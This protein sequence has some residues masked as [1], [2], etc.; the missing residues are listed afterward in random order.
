MKP[1]KQF[2]RRNGKSRNVRLH[3]NRFTAYDL[4]KK[5]KKV[6]LQPERCGDDALRRLLSDENLIIACLRDGLSKPSVRLPAENGTARLLN[7]A[8]GI[9]SG[10]E[11]KCELENILRDVHEFDSA[12][13]LMIRELALLPAALR[14]A[15]CEGLDA[16]CGDILESAKTRER[17]EK[18]VRSGGTARIPKNSRDVFFAHALN[19]TEDR[20]IPQLR[21]KLNSMLSERK[22]RSEWALENAHRI[23]AHNMLRLENL[24]HLK[25]LLDSAD[26]QDVFDALSQA[27]AE[28]AE[29][30]SGVY[31]NMDADSRAWVRSSL[32]YLSRKLRISE[33]VLARHALRLAQS[34]Q[35]AD[36]NAHQS[37]VCWYL[38]DDDGRALLLK[39][40]NIQKRIQKC[41]PDRTGMISVSVVCGLTLLL[42]AAMYFVM[43]RHVLMLYAL[44]LAWAAAIQL[45]SRFFPKFVR[46]GKLLRIELKEIPDH[47]RT[48]VTLPVLISSADRAHEMLRRMEALGCLERDKNID[49]LLLG[50]F[51]DADAQHTD[52]DD[53]ILSV[54]REGIARMN[55]A[56]G[57]EKYFYLHR[58]RSW[59]AKDSRWMGENRKRGAITALNRLL[60][61]KSDDAAQFFSAEHAAAEKL[62]GRYRF[63]LTLDADT[64]YLPGTVHKLVG[65]MLHPMNC[66]YA[67]LQPN[68]QLTVDAVRNRYTALTAG[69][70]GVD[71]YSCRVS[72]FYQD[73]TGFG[74]FAG[75]GIYDI[76]RFH[77]STAGRLPDDAILSHDLIEGILSGT[78][79]VNDISFYDGCPENLT[80][81][82]VRLHRWTRGDWQLLPLIFARR[83]NISL[84]DRM[85][86]AGNLIASLSMPALAGL[87]LHSVWLDAPTAFAVGLVF[88]FLDPLLHLFTGGRRLWKHAALRLAVL[89]VYAR[90][91]FDA[92]ARTIWR[93]MFTGKHLMDWIPAADAGSGSRKMHVPGRTAALLLLPGLLRPQWVPAVLA[94]GMLFWVGTDWADDLA[95]E[96]TD[97]CGR[98][99]SAQIDLLN[100][101]AQETWRFFLQ[102]VPEDGC[103]LPPDNVQK[104]P[105]QGIAMRT[106]PTNIG[107]YMMSCLAAYELGYEGWDT[108]RKRLART[109]D[110]LEKLE[111]WNGQ[112]YNW[113]DIAGLVP[114]RPRY[115]SAVD[116][117][118]LAAVLLL[119]A[120]AVKDRDS[121]LGRRLRML[122][123]NMRLSMLYDDERR[124]FRIGAD[125]ENGRLSQSYYDLYASESRILS[126]CAMML[127]EAPVRHWKQLSR[128]LVRAGKGVALA[129]WSG[130]MFEYMMPEL[131]LHSHRMSLTGQ[132]RIAA[133]ECQKQQGKRCRRPW[134]V[135]E[136]GY[137]AF[138][139]MLNYQYRAFGL[140]ML[141]LN[142]D[143]AENV[144]A[145]YASALALCTCAGD[146]ADNLRK[147]RSMGWADEYGMLE[148]ADYLKRDPKGNP[149]LVQSHMAHHQGMILCALCNALRDNTLCNLF[150]DIPEARALR[151]LLQEKPARKPRI[152]GELRTTVHNR[153]EFME[154]GYGRRAKKDTLAAEVHLLHGAGTTALC[155]ANGAVY[156]WNRGIQLNRFSGDLLNEHEGMCVHLTDAN[157]GES[158]VFGESGDTVF[159]AGC[160]YTRETIGGAEAELQTAVSPETGALIQQITL[161]NR[162]DQNLRIDVA[163]C[164]S[165][166]LA[167][168]AD[169]RAHPAFQNLFVKTEKLPGNALCFIRKPRS[170]DGK[171]LRMLYC[172]S[173][174]F[175]ADVETDFEK[176]IGRTGALG[177]ANG[178]SR[179]F[180]GTT[181]SVLNPCGAIR[182]HVQL[183]AGDTR[184]LCFRLAAG[185]EMP[186]FSAE[187]TLR[188]AETH[189]AAVLND[190][191]IDARMHRLVQRASAFLLDAGLKNKRCTQRNFSRK[192]LWRAGISGDMPILLAEID[193]PEQLRN[194]RE[195]IRIHGFY[196]L[197]GVYSDLVILD[198]CA[199]DYHQPEQN[200]LRDM[201]SAGHLS[202]LVSVPGGVFLLKNPEAGTA[203]AL[204]CAAALHFSGSESI[205]VQLRTQLTALYLRENRRFT[206]VRCDREL[207][208]GELEFGCAYGG[209]DR[210][211]YT[212]LPG[213]G[214][215]PPAPWSNIICGGGFGALLTD[216][217]GGFAWLDNSRNCR[218]T[219]FSNDALQEG[220]GWM[221]YLLDEKKGEYL[222]LLPGSEPLTR[223]RVHFAPNCCE[224]ASQTDS[225]AFSAEFKPVDGGMCMR[226]RLR[227]KSEKQLN[228]RL[229]CVVDW[230]MGTDAGDAALLRTWH[231]QGACFARG[232][233][234]ITSFLASDDPNA[235]A[236]CSRNDFLAGGNLMEPR[237]FD[238]LDRREGG[239]VLHMP[240]NIPSGGAA[241]Y[242][243]LLGGAENTKAAQLKIR[244]FRSGRLR[245]VTGI[246]GL[247]RLIVETPDPAVNRMANGFL[248]AQIL[249]GRI[250]GRTGLYQPGG[251]YGFRDQLQDMLAMIHYRPD[252]VRAHLLKC[253]SRQ[254]E[255]G[256]VLHWWHEPCTGVRT[257][258]SDDLLFLPYVTARYV[259]V[260]GDRS[261]LS[262]CIPYLK[263][264]DIPE[265][266]EDV[267]AEMA[268]SEISESLHSHCMR[269]FRHADRSGMHGLCLMGSGD[270]NDGMNRIGAKGSGESIWLSEFMA[271]CAAEYAGIVPDESD[272]AYLTALNER[273]ITA[274]ETT[275]WDGEWYLRAYGDSGGKIGSVENAECRIDVISQAWAELCGLDGERCASALDAAWRYLADEDTGVIR[276]LT[277][278]FSQKQDVGYIAAYPEGIRE[279]GAQYTHGACWLLCALIHA[280]DAERAHKALHML[281]PVYHADTKEKADIYR[282]EP[283]VMAADVYTD[284]LHS[285]RG[286]WTWYTGA[287][288]WMLQAIWMLLGYERRENRVRLN[289][290]L[291]SWRQA[292]VTVRYGGSEYRLICDANCRITL[293]DGI[294][295]DDAFIEMQD[296]G[297]KHTAVFPPR[298]TGKKAPIPL[299]SEQAQA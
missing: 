48:I 292:S 150:M 114:L 175:T 136:S 196:R 12:N 51:R 180:T 58:E 89:P 207:P 217:A 94:L 284:A 119:C 26:W 93:I 199:G 130:T 171:E 143:A 245:T 275:G 187:R 159:E 190:S 232:A 234:E 105:P 211:G 274:I 45:I 68:M 295:L 268:D 288:S 32:E 6:N 202:E 186:P 225:L 161:K 291:G 221:L 253:A 127:G 39:R 177:K 260:T 167:P 296:D 163:G 193:D 299:K 96:E 276:L 188:L 60:L 192:D 194:M 33:T 88:A 10:G 237:G 116:S 179:N 219:G 118:N 18:W 92:A 244:D 251:A 165:A 133:A 5:L 239:W 84:P 195:I 222:R 107:L 283:Y 258:I 132:T 261:V 23:S 231:H 201:I 285:G 90:S 91:C 278:P 236:G 265:D 9:V 74:N 55:A 82:I 263:N 81:E 86:M 21:E 297:K 63:A 25:R 287:A 54:M 49:Y 62:C 101:L 1:L 249:N 95:S 145:P 280:G 36:G 104:D 134:G 124:L 103:G 149:R 223:F 13:E 146:A 37:T 126:Y 241:E 109:V 3:M 30:P 110:T 53:E 83:L 243:F 228:L 279:N 106:S 2:I 31:P 262:E 7:L 77:E 22:Q 27:E 240:A 100:E 34:A 254:F 129:S 242:S 17:A 85:K 147:M 226:V 112:L 41:V 257:H 294:P 125:V 215:L 191:G 67:V 298:K 282:V 99:N 102:Y 141:A 71:G 115:V 40:L 38:A 176:L 181:G 270:W 250:L 24:M 113:Y 66:R 178:I 108:L 256:D 286:G 57:R 255:D 162:T 20:E 80:A 152:R 247:D 117:G 197:M 233:A 120:Q 75:K 293:L 206:P 184:K 160:V 65:A 272:C 189:A 121:A 151:L 154:T 46:P 97:S 78:G 70:G 172:A 289:A 212:V 203:E 28:L 208:A 248:Q 227:S 35:D 182:L 111:K 148:A 76:R 131:L 169:M 56:A 135:S 158:R 259:R 183:H 168:Q 142:G 205:A 153:R 166:A 229:V 264:R 138:D 238:A 198:R 174:G 156:V 157:T 72:D 122:A 42:A 139:M 213:K 164:F 29:D 216:R 214:R 246:E 11:Q 271:V 185:D 230:L 87:F 204:R 252:M 267:Y 4:Q 290:L 155:S 220:W 79:F 8:R 47:A 123:E 137:Y 98:L 52:G 209:F 200:A 173:E 59:R 61:G 50:D 281:L 210:D 269:A 14:I 15:L 218:L 144:A 170:H 235:A 273:L 16:V 19:L 140:R 277:P 44:P 224:Y 69:T 64:E 73:M 128:P 266:S 43:D